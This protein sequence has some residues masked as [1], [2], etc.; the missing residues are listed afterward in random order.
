MSLH[1][2]LLFAAAYLI[3]TIS[4]GPNVLLVIRNTVRPGI[5]EPFP[6]MFGYDQTPLTISDVLDTDRWTPTIRS[7]VSGTPRTPRRQDM[8]QDMWSGTLRSFNSS[9]NIAG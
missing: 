1:T 7:W 3:T 6:P 4:P 5:N 2:W 9:P 8:Q